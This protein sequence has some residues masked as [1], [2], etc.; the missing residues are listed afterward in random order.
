MDLKKMIR[1]IPDFPEKGV[2]FRDVTTL[3][4]DAEGLHEAVD[5]IQKELEGVEFDA[6]LGPESRG[7][8]FG[9]PI[10]YNLKKG[11]IPVRK[12][13]KLPAEVI[14]REYALEYG[15]AIIEIHKDAIRPGMKLVVIDDLMATGGTAKA[16]VD[17]IRE[18]GAEV[19]KLVFLIELDGLKGRELLQDCDVSSILHY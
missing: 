11:F 19:V 10:S 18:A 2:L 15:T 13:G 16:L 9:M 4:K 17:M 5:L 6:V 1:E 8:I 12:K 3:L 7:F 14:S